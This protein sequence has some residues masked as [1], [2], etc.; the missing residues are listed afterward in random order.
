MAKNKSKTS[1]SQNQTYSNQANYGWQAPPDT[2]DTKAYRAYRPEVDPS[3]AYGAA[4]A[5]NR[6][7]SSFVNPLGGFQ[8]AQNQ[9]ALLRAG[10]R[11]I[12]QDTSQAFRMGQYDQ[13][14]QRASQL[15]GLAALTS[16]RLVQ[17]SSSGSSS[18]TGTSNTTQGQNLFGDLMSGAQGAASIALL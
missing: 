17:Q 13:N 5:R 8:S 15:G 3:I 14:Q 4:N 16:P 6:L 18:G 12:D 1:Q 11:Q 2:E 10:N 9:D 7:N